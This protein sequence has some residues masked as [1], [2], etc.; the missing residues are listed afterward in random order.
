MLR[1]RALA[2]GGV[3]RASRGSRMRRFACALLLC[4][5]GSGCLPAR[6]PTTGPAGESAG[7]LVLYL[8]PLSRDSGRPTFHLDEISAQR[9]DGTVL[10]LSLPHAGL[11]AGGRTSERR[12][13]SQALP[14]G[15]Y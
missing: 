9:E 7:A 15:R 1:Y 2:E 3:G 11:E 8:I 4:L 5:L 14:Q 13:A 10:P 12:L 6:H